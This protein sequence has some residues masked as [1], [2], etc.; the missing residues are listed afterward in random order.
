MRLP[1]CGDKVIS[2]G[3]SHFMGVKYAEGA[4]SNFSSRPS[5]GFLEILNEVEGYGVS[6]ARLFGAGEILIMSSG[7][8][9]S[10][11]LTDVLRSSLDED[12]VPVVGGRANWLGE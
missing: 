7:E 1:S 11:D 9:S 12:E 3:K 4:E 5:L 2:T 10:L 8:V 6:L